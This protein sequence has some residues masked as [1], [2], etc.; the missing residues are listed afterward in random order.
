M[1]ELKEALYE[2]RQRKTVNDYRYCSISIN[3]WLNHFFIPT[4]QKN[5]RARSS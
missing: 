5:I 3:N 2:L 4:M 1:E